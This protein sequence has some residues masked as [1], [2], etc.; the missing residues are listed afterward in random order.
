MAMAAT[1]AK[2]PRRDVAK[3]R[4]WRERI[5][6]WQRSGQSVSGFCRDEGLSKASFYFWRKELQRRRAAKRQTESQRRSSAQRAAAAPQSAAAFVPVR[7]RGVVDRTPE[8]PS[9]VEVLL[10]GGV[11]LRVPEHCPA[12]RVRELVEAL[13]ARSC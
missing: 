8:S 7:V 13:E 9:T 12:A 2:G 5:A 3:E 6:A 1:K 11:V 10:P 4:A